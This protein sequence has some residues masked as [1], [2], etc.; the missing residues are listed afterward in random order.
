[1]GHRN[2]PGFFQRVSEYLCTPW[3]KNPGVQDFREFREVKDVQAFRGLAGFYRSYIKNFAQ[4]TF[5]MQTS[6]AHGTT[7]A[8]GSGWTLSPPC[9]AP[10]MDP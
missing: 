3:W 6:S 5:A 1:M 4:R 2:S 10:S 7:R 9:R 8:S